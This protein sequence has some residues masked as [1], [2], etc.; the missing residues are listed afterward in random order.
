MVIRD[1]A[2]PQRLS[3]VRATALA[4][5]AIALAG[6][7]GSGSAES[8]GAP[9]TTEASRCLPVAAEVVEAI[10]SGLLDGNT[11]RSARAV[12]SDDYVNIYFVSAEIDGPGVEGAGEVGT[13]ALNRIDSVAGLIFAVGGHA[14]QFSDWGH[15]EKTDA[16]FSLARDGAEE[17]RACVSP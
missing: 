10:E 4:G 7:G 5:V 2:V 17:S 15:G 12:K 14:H 11:L 6:C 3:L 13:W 9:A 16:E 1:G 8:G